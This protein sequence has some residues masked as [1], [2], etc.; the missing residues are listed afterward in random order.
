MPNIFGKVSPKK[1]FFNCN[2]RG[3]LKVLSAR[4]LKKVSCKL[5]MNQ[6]FLKKLS[7]Q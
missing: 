4:I 7:E 2:F 6:H 5:F 1:D 3:K